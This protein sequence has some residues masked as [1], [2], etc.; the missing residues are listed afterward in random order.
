MKKKLI[1]LLL[2]LIIVITGGLFYVFGSLDHFV[3]QQIE[4]QGSHA[5]Q[6]D[7]EVGSVELHLMNGMGELSGLQVDNPT[8]F[9]RYPAL[10]VKT[11]TLHIDT[12]SL[13]AIPMVIENIMVDS[14][15][16][17]Y[18][19]NNEGKANLNVLF[20]NVKKAASASAT[21]QESASPEPGAP[22][23]DSGLRLSVKKL[24]VKN[25]ALVLDLTALG[26]QEYQEVLPTFVIEN[27]GGP[28]GVPPQQLGIK[29]MQAILD[30]LLAAAKEK[31]A[32]KLK[33]KVMEKIEE[34]TQEGIKS[35]MDKFGS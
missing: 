35:L 14:L 32:E 13:G 24:T 2:L 4:K 15:A 1:V 21:D 17:R 31:Q 26:D 18:E 3:A 23:Q 25:T 10:Q 30:Q 29:I 28:Q 27:V 33:G 16:S 6:T 11:V 8:G 34:S 20:E 9:S 5:L 12:R 7:V 22:K 19:F